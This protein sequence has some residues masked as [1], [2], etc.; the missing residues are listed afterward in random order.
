MQA[1]TDGTPRLGILEVPA[2]WPCGSAS[3][4]EQSVLS[5][6]ELVSMNI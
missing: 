1:L 5:I 6:M 3:S 4:E 2:T